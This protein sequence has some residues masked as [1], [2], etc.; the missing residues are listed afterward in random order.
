MGNQNTQGNEE[1][2]NKSTSG[3]AGGDELNTDDQEMSGK[4]YSENLMDKAEKMHDDPEKL[5]NYLTTT[6]AE[7]MAEVRPE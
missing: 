6:G 7:R 4:V 3:Y 2:V 5:A 1:N